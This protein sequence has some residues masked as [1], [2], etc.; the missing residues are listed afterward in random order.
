MPPCFPRP[1]RHAVLT[2][3]LDDATCQVVFHAL[4]VAHATRTAVPPPLPCGSDPRGRTM[5]AI[6]ELYAGKLSPEA[7]LAVARSEGAG[8]ADRL[9]VGE[10]SDAAVLGGGALSEPTDAATNANCSANYYIGAF[11]EANGQTDAALRHL[12]AAAA[13]PSSDFMGR[14]AIMHQRLSAS[15]AAGRVQVPR[16]ARRIG[17]YECPRVIIGGWQLSSGHSTHPEGSDLAAL[18]ARCQA[19]LTAHAAAGLVAFDFGDIYSG[20]ELIVGRFVRDHI[21]HGGRRS[22]L[23]L[24]TKLVPDLDRLATYSPADVGAVVRRSCARLQSS[25]VDLVQ[26]H[27]ASAGLEPST[28][29]SW[30]A[31]LCPRLRCLLSH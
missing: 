7:V 26:F 21:A 27:C 9:K 19:D 10:Y 6:R 1:P 30:V 18:R 23:A 4:S 28:S 16:A 24:H 20:V 12:A 15:T 22:E 3:S 14:I 29:G 11:Y 2:V 25:Y 31:S 17:G 5:E 13:A 8:M